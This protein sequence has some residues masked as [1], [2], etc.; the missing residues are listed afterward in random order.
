M[1]FKEQHENFKRKE[2]RCGIYK[3]TNNINNKCYIG[4]S[5]S[6]EQ[7]WKEHLSAYNWEREKNKPLYLAFQKYGIENFSFEILEECENIRQLLNEKEQFWINY[8]DSTNQTKGYNITPGGDG[9]GG[10]EAHPNHKITKEDVIDIRTRYANK[11]RKKDVE[12]LYKNKIGSSGFN[13]IWQGTTWSDIMPEVYTKENKEFHKNNTANK[14]SSNGRSKLTEK[15]VYNIR[16]R[17]K[18]GENWQEVFKDYEHT[19]IKKSSFQYT[20]Q[21]YN[22]KHIVVE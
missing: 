6:I 19:G 14:G 12:E 9:H 8:Y 2:N 1:S 11:E 7:R 13:K 16:L 20:W 15:D 4:K 21:G 5:V 10:G 22:W 3:I 18:N 17:K